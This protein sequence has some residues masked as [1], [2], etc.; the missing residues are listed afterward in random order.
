MEGL[1]ASLGAT[2]R[3]RGRFAPSPTGSLHLGSLVAALASFL[4]VR[5]QGGE[6]LVRIEDIDPP[7]EPQGASAEIL[8]QLQAYQLLPDQPVLYQST[9][10]ARYREVLHRL[11]DAGVAF[12]CFCTRSQLAQRPH[13]G[14]CASKS[15][16]QP[17]WRVLVSPQLICFHDQIQ[18]DYQQDLQEIGD[19]VIWRA[20]GWPAYQLAC[21]VDDADFGI[22]EIVRGV[23]L[24]DS[25]PRQIFLQRLLGWPQPRY[26]HLP[27]VLGADGRKLSKQ[28]LAAAL[29]VSSASALQNLRF[30]Q[31][32]L[33]QPGNPC[34]DLRDWLKQAI[35]DWQ[36]QRIHPNCG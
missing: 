17:S 22:T 23:D 6:W 12:P 31:Q 30:A 8:A 16:N 18:G 36:I 26:A 35:G 11:I 28:N 32:F 21:V 14:R 1:D 3:P 7:R 9:R 20:D 19:F 34:S 29:D 24:I 13:L 15:R 2:A 25:T 10:L 4:N 5:A 33:S 27:V